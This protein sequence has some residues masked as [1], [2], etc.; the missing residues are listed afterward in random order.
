[1]IP[2][3]ETLELLKAL[4]L[5]KEGD[6]FFVE[7]EKCNYVY[8]NN[9]WIPEDTQ[10]EA[11]IGIGSL[12][13]LNKEIMSQMPG[14]TPE[15]WMKAYDLLN[16]FIVSKNNKYYMLLSHEFR[17]YTLFVRN[18]ASEQPIELAVGDCLHNWVVKS[19]ELTNNNDA[20]EIW[21]EVPEV[22]TIVFYFFPYDLGVIE[23]L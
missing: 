5:S 19:I 2:S 10:S 11:V 16:E 1:M 6:I 18:G 7:S 13:D 22:G 12:Y 15:N 14:L 23:C 17:Y 3:I 9:E 4:P 21:A 8:H 20:I